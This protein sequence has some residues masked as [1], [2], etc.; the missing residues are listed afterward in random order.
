MECSE[1]NFREAKRQ[2][3]SALKKTQ[4]VLKTFGEKENAHRYKFQITLTKRKNLEPG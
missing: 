1:D 3:D 2:I 4:A